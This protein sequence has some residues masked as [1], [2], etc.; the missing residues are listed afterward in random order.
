MQRRLAGFS[1][2]GRSSIGVFTP[3]LGEIPSATFSDDLGKIELSYS[4]SGFL[5]SRRDRQTGMPLVNSRCCG[6]AGQSETFYANSSAWNLQR[7]DCDA[8]VTQNLPT[9]TILTFL[10]FRG[11][12]ASI[13][14]VFATRPGEFGLQV[15]LPQTY[16]VL[17]TCKIDTV[18]WD[19]RL[20]AARPFEQ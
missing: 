10:T 1:E 19:Q 5:S 6:V 11:S 9:L 16:L 2:V 7:P 18:N 17:P 3:R 8:G 12:S 20:V 13:T 14:C 15:R 4:F